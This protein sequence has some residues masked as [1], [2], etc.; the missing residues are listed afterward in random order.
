[1]YMVLP[2]ANPT[3]SKDGVYYF[4][5]RVPA[6]LVQKV[7]KTRYSFSLGTKDPKVARQLF[8]DAMTQ[9][10]KEHAALRAVPAP[11]PHK[12]LVELTGVAYREFVTSLEDEPGEATI[13]EHYN[14]LMEGLGATG[15]DARAKWHGDI[16]DKL[17]VGEGLAADDGSRSR[18]IEE[19]HKAFT[20]AGQFQKRRA[21]GD[22]SPDENLKRFPAPPAAHAV[23]R[24]A[25]AATA[26][27]DGEAVTITSL[28]EL[29]KRDHL[30]NGRAPA[31]V[32]EYESKT[33]AFVKWL[34]HDDALAVTGKKIAEYCDHLRHDVGLT[35]KTVGGKYLTFIKALFRTGK[36][37]FKLTT[38]VAAEVNY[39]IVKP[40]QGRGK[41]YTDAEAKRILAAANRSLMANDKRST[42]NKIA[43]RW[44]PWLCAYTGA[45]VSEITQMNKAHL[46]EEYGIA[47]INITPD[48]GSVKTGTY[49]L[50][51]IHPHLIAMGFVD[52]VRSRPDGPLFYEQNDRKRKERNTQAKWAGNAVGRWIKTVSGVDDARVKPNHAFRHRFKTVGR[53]AGIE[54]HYLDAIQG[55]ADGRASTDYGETTM[56]ALYREIQKLPRIQVD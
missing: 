48:A 53:D 16:A 3:K 46:F 56:K 38:N 54:L 24:P 49:R 20:L 47:T 35:S 17:L 25:I 31:T 13:W 6:D 42:M 55:H 43:C 36:D 30:A 12:K 18:L 51:P 19:L 32:E 26:S 39:T 45:R 29:W 7:G 8:L 34:G 23:F 1:M 27:V 28:F 40:P 5:Q 33:K 11:I 50:V 10:E 15:P 21:E 37:K 41:G 4:I 14:S 22:Y 44:V 9:K 52:F 2:M